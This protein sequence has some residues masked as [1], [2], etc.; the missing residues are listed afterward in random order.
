MWLTISAGD[1]SGRSVHLSTGSHI[2]GRASTCDI[3][4][5]DR[6]VSQRHARLEVENAGAWLTDL[7]STNGTFVN[8][9]P[10]DRPV[11]VAAPSEFRLG[12]TTVRLRAE[13]PTVAL[14]SAMPGSTIPAPSGRPEPY[15]PPPPASPGPGRPVGP[16]A[17]G[18]SY[19]VRDAGP[20]GGRDVHMG[21]HQVAGRDMFIHE[22]F[23]LRTQMRASAKNAIRIGCL[24]FLAGVALF[25]YFVITW[26]NK[27][28]DAV[29]DP[30]GEP[31]NDLPSPLPWLPLGAA[32]AFTGFALIVVG[33][34][35]PRDR[36]VTRGDR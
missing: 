32:L 29:T 21:G 6:H 7:G 1:S 34:L 5:D 17:P 23:K 22:G 30:S 20:V 8:R 33:L 27:I 16:R 36:V 9:V 4:I 13:D 10:I 18:P 31:P 2:I 15:P 26:N 12:E 35:I 14:D 3:V 24:T 19:D 25:G 28:F 11:W